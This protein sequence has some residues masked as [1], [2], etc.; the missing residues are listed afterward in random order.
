[1]AG[2]ST[3]EYDQVRTSEAESLGV[4]AATLDAEVK[5]AR[6]AASSESNI[7]PEI[8]PW[9]EIVDGEQ[10]LN[11]MVSIFKRYAI[12]PDHAPEVAALWIV[13]TYVHD[14]GYNSPMIMITSPEKR[15]GKTTTLNLLQ[16]LVNKPLPAGNI[17]PAAIYRAIEKWQPALLI[18]EADTFLK[19]NEEVAGVI[20]SGHTKPSAFVIRC[21]GENNE[22]KQFSTWCPKVIAGIGS[23]R[24][25][26]EDRSIIFPLRR[27][28]P[29]EQVER[30]RLDREGFDDL[31]RKCARWAIDNFTKCKNSDPL[32][33]QEL[34]DRANDNWLPLLAI[35]DLCNWSGG[36]VPNSLN[37]TT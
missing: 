8:E 9:G 19:N 2:L 17:S 10:L 23:Q 31:K 6:K 1:L 12:L 26:L 35:A 16:A 24:D 13:N 3:L 22:P 18:D 15:C 20:N 11:D 32:P 29:H 28:L 25:T 30:L 33:I 36:H 5:A 21:D 34:E 7:F 27:K 37:I 14:A 4:R